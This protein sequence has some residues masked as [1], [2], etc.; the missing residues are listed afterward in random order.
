MI[1]NL[2]ISEKFSDRQLLNE[3]SSY[4]ALRRPG[5]VIIPLLSVLEKIGVL[6]ILDTESVSTLRRLRNTVA[7][8]NFEVSESDAKRYVSQCDEITQKVNSFQ[9]TDENFE[10]IFNFI[11]SDDRLSRWWRIKEAN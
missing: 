2:N 3:N 9:I 10:E 11:A 4:R 1:K 8:S 5:T 6:S 7:H